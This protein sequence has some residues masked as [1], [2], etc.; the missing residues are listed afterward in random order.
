MVDITKRKVAEIA[1][2]ENEKRFK[3]L[4]ENGQ[5]AIVVFDADG[6]PKYISSSIISN[7]KDT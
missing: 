2:R 6:V 1:L 3:A 7:T 4:I 5:D